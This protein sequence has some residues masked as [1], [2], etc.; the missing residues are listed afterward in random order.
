MLDD[1]SEVR[2]IR[3]VHEEERARCEER[4]RDG[5]RQDEREVEEVPPAYVFITFF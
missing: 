5:D 2:A 4:V 1:E 3:V